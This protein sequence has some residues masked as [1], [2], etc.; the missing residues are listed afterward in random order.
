MYHP[1]FEDNGFGAMRQNAV[2]QMKSHLS[3]ED[4]PL[5]VFTLYLQPHF[6]ALYMRNTIAG[7]E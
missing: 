5:Y 4:C 6:I 1:S 7:Q 3:G 2:F